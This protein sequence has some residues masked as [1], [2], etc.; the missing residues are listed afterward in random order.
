MKIKWQQVGKDD[1]M[2]EYI[3]DIKDDILEKMKKVNKQDNYKQLYVK[4]EDL[5]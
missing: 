2:E 1:K 4:M 5:I 3:I